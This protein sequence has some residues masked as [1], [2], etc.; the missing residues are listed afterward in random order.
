MTKKLSLKDVAGVL[1]QFLIE[2]FE[3]RSRL[4]ALTKGLLLVSSLNDGLDDG[5]RATMAKELQSGVM[6]LELLRDRLL[7]E[8]SE[9]ILEHRE[10][11]L[12]SESQELLNGKRFRQEGS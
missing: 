12:L 5:V 9:E 10:A 3:L 4:N 6:M 2:N 7:S 8:T 1:D 11:S